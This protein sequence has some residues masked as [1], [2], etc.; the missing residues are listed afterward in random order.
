[1]TT[2]C[3]SSRPVQPDYPPLRTRLRTITRAWF[4]GAGWSALTSGVIFFGFAKD[5]G[6]GQFA[7]A[8]GWL[9]AMPFAAT[10]FQVI[11][12]LLAE[13]S[14]Q[15][16]R[17]A[18]IGFLVQRLTW[19]VIALLP[20]LVSPGAST[21]IAVLM[22]LFLLQS[23]GGQFGTPPITA[24]MADLVPARIRSR[25]LGRRHRVAM[26]MFL[27]MAVMSGWLLSAARAG[28]IRLPWPSGLFDWHLRTY[29]F[30]YS[31]LTLCSVLF[32]MAAILGAADILIFLRMPETDGRPAADRPSLMKLLAG[33][34]RDRE[35]MRFMT[36]YTLFMLGTPGTVYYIWQNATD[37][38]GVSAIGVQFMFV[39]FPVLGELTFAPLWG[40]L[41]HRLGRKSFMYLSMAYAVVLPTCW[42]FVLPQY[43][44]MGIAI[45]VIGNIC[46]IGSDLCVF[47]WLLHLVGGE[48]GNAGYQAVF[49]LAVAVAGTASGLLLGWLAKL[50]T[51]IHGHVGPFQVNY[52]LLV[53]GGATLIRGTAY[54]FLL[55]RLH[56]DKTAQPLGQAIRQFAGLVLDALDTAAA[57]FP[58]LRLFGL[59]GRSPR[60][61]RRRDDPTS[62]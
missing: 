38:L 8:W 37:Y 47:N 28:T 10:F 45:A 53:F 20:W 21:T 34:L 39:I 1:M 25:Y 26:C 23:A 46:W 31:P 14:G 49:A 55:P 48:R 2:S 22:L 58:P 7:S 52:L 15:N 51:H 4:F 27:F 57:F 50:G 29:E 36:F 41:I 17:L 13:R 19:A 59:T 35:F 12:S 3:A 54:L 56:D 40:R 61:S 42:L 6:V 11:A 30:P 43:W 33:P 18:G 62:D 60:S 5:M 32:V 44:W 24:W 9:S 16:R